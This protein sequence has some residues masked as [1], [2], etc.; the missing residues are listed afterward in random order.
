MAKR[1]IIHID[2][3][4]FYASVE[5]AD[6]PA[7]K[8][9]PVIVGADPKGGQGRGVVAAS[10]YAARAFGVR[11][12]MPVSKAYRLC[13][14]GIFVAPRMERYIEVSHQVFAIF[15]RYTDLV[16]GLSLD[17]AFLD[18]TGSELLFGDARTIAQL[19]K[20]EIKAETGLVCSVGV[21]ASK[22]VAKIASDIKKPDGFVAV[23]GAQT[24]AF[25]WPLPVTRLWG[26]GEKTA[27]TLQR[28]GLRTIGDV[29]ALSPSD[30]R[31]ILGDHGLHL[32]ALAR[33]EDERAVVPDQAAKSV[34]AEVT[35]E[36]DTADRETIQR[37]L[38]ALADRVAARLR[39]EGVMAGGVTLKFR[40]ESFHT[41]T[42]S[43]T[44]SEPTD[45]TGNLYL[46]GLAL[47]ERTGWHCERKV[48][49]VGLT[50]HKL[51]KEGNPQADLFGE[52]KRSEKERRAE[53]AVDKI[54]KKF[55]KAALKRA[56]LIR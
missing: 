18:V 25:L 14:T 10:S 50:G 43:L 35:F 9:R 15:R 51:E 11:S 37:T 26:V 30:A 21:A 49:L 42:R 38:L 46:A 4:A 29:A 48:R 54:R 7:Y 32:L 2:M 8:G 40:D 17:E 6:N 56:A 47:L 1:Q 52:T 39:R 19:I 55:G 31:A 27:E 44:L 5:E 24:Q 36:E 3:D 41:V 13:P 12:A 34:G 53:E 16:E 33:G 22:F 20:E 23:D 28:R 45:V